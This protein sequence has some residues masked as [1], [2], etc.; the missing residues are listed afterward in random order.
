MEVN[1]CGSAA[2]GWAVDVGLQF[3][4]AMSPS[5]VGG[6]TDSL[7]E[8]SK[9]RPAIVASIGRK[10]SVNGWGERQICLFR[11]HRSPKECTGRPTTVFDD[12]TTRPKRIHM[13]D[14]SY[15]AVSVPSPSLEGTI[16]A[17]RVVGL[18]WM[19]YFP[20]CQKQLLLE[21]AIRSLLAPDNERF[22]EQLAT[23]FLEHG[24]PPHLYR[25]RGLQ[26]K[27]LISQRARASL[28]PLR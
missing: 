21:H 12:S 19:S 1:E 13:H 17:Q 24:G 3:C 23:S 2:H 8:A 10:Q 28:S 5:H 16:G 20:V 27:R 22:A 26:A 25:F 9:L 15:V 14:G 7:I 4:T 6:V 18:E 11:S